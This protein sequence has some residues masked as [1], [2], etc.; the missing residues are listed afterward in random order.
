MAVT[1]PDN[2]AF[3]LQQE[4]FK[5]K[6][7]ITY[8]DY[9]EC[10]KAI[11][12]ACGGSK[13]DKNMFGAYVEPCLAT[14]STALSK[15][16]ANNLHLL[17]CSETLTKLA[18]LTYP[19]SKKHVEKLHSRLEEL[20]RQISEHERVAQGYDKRCRDLC[21]HWGVSIDHSLSSG[22]SSSTSSDTDSITSCQNTEVSASLMRQLQFYASATHRQSVFESQVRT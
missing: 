13:G 1:L 16:E 12:A 2:L 5:S 10:L 21:Q 14:V 20:T 4:S 17:S 11:A 19:S 9:Q 7:L 15:W 8:Y 18:H 22:T 6:S 3:L